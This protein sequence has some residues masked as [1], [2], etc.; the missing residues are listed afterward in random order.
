[1]KRGF[2]K[3]STVDSEV[4]MSGRTEGKTEDWRNIAG[5]EQRVPPDKAKKASSYGRVR[6]KPR[7]PTGEDGKRKGERRHERWL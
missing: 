1:M 7:K 4:P 5:R 2:A 3:L 6:R